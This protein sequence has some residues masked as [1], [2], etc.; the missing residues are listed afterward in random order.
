MTKLKSITLDATTVFPQTNA[1]MVPVKQL[2]NGSIIALRRASVPPT[3]PGSSSITKYAVAKIDA[4]GKV[5]TGKVLSLAAT[6]TMD[7][8]AGANLSRQSV[9]SAGVVNYYYTSKY[10]PDGKYKVVTWKNPTS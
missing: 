4:T 1:S 7:T 3:G 5:T 8:Y 10:S 9:T 2:A 6:N